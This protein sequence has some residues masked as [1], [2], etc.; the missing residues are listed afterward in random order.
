[1]NLWVQPTHF[2]VCYRF[3][4]FSYHPVQI[5]VCFLHT[6]FH[7]LKR[8]CFSFK[9]CDK[10]S[11][12]GY[13]TI[14]KQTIKKS[15]QPIFFS[16]FTLKINIRLWKQIDMPYGAI[17]KYMLCTLH[18]VKWLEYVISF[19]K[20]WNEIVKY[21]IHTD[22]QTNYRKPKLTSIDRKF[23]RWVA[24]SFYFSFFHSNWFRNW[25]QMFATVVLLDV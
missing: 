8:Q 21:A 24:G 20:K 5:F 6:L 25:L 16:F 4:S 12:D 10:Q 7:L 9:R 17:H 11:W 22:T 2:A 14:S 3:L 1:M 13:G 15:N 23:V 18:V 19:K